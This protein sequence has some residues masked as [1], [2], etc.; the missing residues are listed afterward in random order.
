MRIDTD[1]L[2]ILAFIIEDW[3]R[4]VNWNKVEINAMANDIDDIYNL[5]CVELRE[6]D[7]DFVG[8]MRR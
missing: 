1:S 4:L 2:K 3:N 8:S 5:I 7:I 6:R